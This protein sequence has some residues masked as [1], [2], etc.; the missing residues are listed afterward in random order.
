MG[1][2]VGE[3]NIHDLQEIGEE[4]YGRSQEVVSYRDG[5]ETGNLEVEDI[6]N[7]DLHV[8]ISASLA[9]ITCEFPGNAHWS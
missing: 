6:R 3:V 8:I 7:K 9:T 1:K 4:R 2:N 5:D